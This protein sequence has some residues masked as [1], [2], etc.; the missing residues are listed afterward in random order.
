MSSD[1]AVRKAAIK[2]VKKNKK[3]ITSRFADLIKFPP[4]QNPFTV[5][6]AGSPGAGKTEFS[7]SLIKQ[8]S[9]KDPNTKV[10]RIDADEIRDII[11]QYDKTNSNLI[12]S[13]AAIGVEKL[14]DHIQDHAQNVVVDGTFANFEVAL[15]DIKRSL[16]KNRKV[17][18][19]Y[20]YQDPA[21][22]WDFTKKREKLEGRI[23][24]KEM[25]IKAFINSKENV[26]KIKKE[27]GNNVRLS[28]V[29]KNFENRVEKTLFNIDNVDSYLKTKYNP[30]TIRK[31]LK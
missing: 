5:F 1:E 20:L 19:I 14:F 27:F 8:L 22:A 21:I 4:S 26:I 24:P 13:A 7:I 28:L 10:V 12:Q 17:G 16:G 30:Q 15:K 3:L 18:I 11:P 6:M 29:I 31:V 23:V 2:F 25:F 9:K